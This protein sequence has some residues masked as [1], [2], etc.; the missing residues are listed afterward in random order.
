MIRQYWE[1]AKHQLADIRLPDIKDRLDFSRE[2]KVFESFAVLCCFD[3]HLV[4]SSIKANYSMMM[5]D[6]CLSIDLPAHLIGDSG[7]ENPSEVSQIVLDLMDVMGLSSS[8]V[9]LLLSSSKFSHY[10]FSVDQISSWDL[11][12]MKLR[13]KSPFLADETLLDLHPNDHSL[14][15][16]QLIRGVS[17][18]NNQLVS[19]WSNVLQAVGK[20]VLGIS[21]LYSG[22]LN[23]LFSSSNSLKNTVVCD[24]EPNCCNLLIKYSL[25]GSQTFQ[26]PFG[27]SLYSGQSGRL[28][29]QFFK[30]LQ[31][32][33]DVIKE[34]QD[35]EERMSC[36][37]SGYG[38]GDFGP[39]LMSSLGSWTLLDD[40]TP[41]RPQISNNLK[42]DELS[43]HQ[44]LFPQ[45]CLCLAEYLQL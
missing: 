44:H 34:D 16:D 37:I 10:S 6:D 30:R 8:P 36:I 39:T 7:V 27:T 35:L 1:Q 40:M 41:V 2:P 43:R 21:P 32:S 26:L 29:D 20:P 31:S 5:V 33:L 45:L 3:Q 11:S 12:D 18:A 38:L 14:S 22:L 4:L 19:S 24:V 28:L 17:Y 9:L 42:P 13:A 23:W 15:D 25:F